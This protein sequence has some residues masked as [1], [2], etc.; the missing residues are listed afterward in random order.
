M[1]TPTVKGAVVRATRRIV[2]AVVALVVAGAGLGV[3]GTP[4]ALAETD[5]DVEAGYGDGLYVPGRAL[6]VRVRI[7]ADRLVS[8]ELRVELRSLGG[9]G[10]MPVDVPVEVPGGSTKDIVVAVPTPAF[11]DRLEV[12]AR[13]D[14]GGAA[15]SGEAELTTSVDTELVGL[16][17]GLVDRVPEPVAVPM[18]LGTARFTNLDAELPVAG[19]LDPL[20]TIITG[21]QGLGDLE[22]EARRNVLDWIDRGG[23][24]VVDTEPGGRIEGLPTEWQPG[25]ATRRPAGQGEIRLSGGAASEGRWGDVVE[26]T[27]LVQPGDVMMTMQFSM[28][29]VASGVARDGGF[30]I[31]TLGWL[32]VFL[33]VYV[34]LAGPVV[35]FVIRR[36]AALWSWAVLPALA[37]VFAAVAFVVGSDARSASQSAHG[38]AVETGP[39]G[40]RASTY[41]GLVSRSGADGE[42][43]FPAGWSVEEG[44]GLSGAEIGVAVVPAMPGGDMPEPPAGDGGSSGRVT[45]SPDATTGEIELDPGDF[46]VLTASGPLDA[47][48]SGLEVTATAAADG[49]LHGTVRNTTDVTL[50]QV[51]VLVGDRVWDGGTLEPGQEV[52]WQLGAAE[53]AVGMGEPPEEP[54]R[55]AIGWDGP[56]DPNSPVN[57][58]LWAQLRARMTDPYG[59]GWVT[60]AGWTR[61]WSPPVDPGGELTAGRTVFTTRAPV[62]AEAGAVPADAVRREFLRGREATELPPP[63][64]PAADAAGEDGKAAEPAFDDMAFDEWSSSGAVARF[65]LP[66]D[67]DP[68]TPLEVALPGAIARAEVWAGGRWVPLAEPADRPADI[69]DPYDPRAARFIGL[70]GGSVQDGAVY[71]RVEVYDDVLEPTMDFSVRGVGA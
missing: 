49:S 31:P 70:P 44:P 24:L 13:L 2:V 66:P 41:L 36:R 39:A 64:D 16:L 35:F 68:A 5:L 19:A 57:Y 63:P 52:E 38:T 50:R 71:L 3:V 26:P 27:S 67:A 62:A 46:G 20:G 34:V 14:A 22:G 56:P 21:P 25:D 32:L 69:Q 55:E 47:D 37:L 12:R 30:R 4:A 15:I 1:R 29:D 59:P 65:V 53:G 17:P 60:A 28:G 18:D 10:Q 7:T 40:A 48:T 58:E 45:V 51:I 61:D 54:W 43:R 6:P 8:G 33:V 9:G 42:A 11:T 23:H